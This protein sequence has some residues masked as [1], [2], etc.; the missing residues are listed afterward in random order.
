M[1]AAE[2]GIAAAVEEQAATTAVMTR[3]AANT[4]ADV[5]GIAQASR[6]V[7]AATSQAGDSIRRITTSTADLT[8]LAEELRGIAARFRC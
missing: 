1:A 4:A 7:A 6:E 2:Q 8:T 5:N 3:V